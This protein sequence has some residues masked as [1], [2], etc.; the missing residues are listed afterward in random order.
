MW[1]RLAHELKNL[2]DICGFVASAEDVAIEHELRESNAMKR[3]VIAHTR[4]LAEAE[5]ILDDIVQQIEAGVQV[6]YVR[7]VRSKLVM[8]KTEL[9]KHVDIRKS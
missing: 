8:D 6:V 4:S 9:E 3:V 7:P 2:D 5:Q 1:I